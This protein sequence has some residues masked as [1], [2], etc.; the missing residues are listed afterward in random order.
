MATP[1][2]ARPSNWKPAT[3][4]EVMDINKVVNINKYDRSIKP[5]KVSV[6]D[7]ISIIPQKTRP[8]YKTVKD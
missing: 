1:K 4:E 2:M 3:I 6:S 7:T 5:K 8:K